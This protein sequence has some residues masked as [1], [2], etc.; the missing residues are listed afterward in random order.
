MISTFHLYHENIEKILVDIVVVF[1]IFLNIYIKHSQKN[2][3]FFL[4]FGGM[5]YFVFLIYSGGFLHTGFLWVLTFSAFAFLLNNTENGIRWS[6][7]FGIV[8][9]LIFIISNISDFSIAYSNKEMFI[10]ICV[11][12]MNSYLIY[13]FQKEVDLYMLRLTELNISLENRVESEIIKSKKKDQ[14]LNAQAKHAQMG[15]MISMIAHQ[16]RQPI[17]AISASAIKLK[18]END[19]GLMSVKKV[20]ETS[21]FIQESTQKMS[22]IINSF[23]EFSKPIREDGEFALSR[24]ISK[25]LKII[26]MQLHLN[27]IYIYLEYSDEAKDK[28]VQGSSNLFEQVILNLLINIKDAFEEHKELREK[29]VFIS[30][31][32]D[33][34]VKITDTA[35]GIKA[36]IIEKVFNPYFTTKEEGKGTGL[37]LYMSR[38]IMRTHFN[39]DLVYKPIENGSCFEIILNKDLQKESPDV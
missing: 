28:I 3:I 11:Y 35:G 21:E 20:N 32:N 37:G 33:G 7:T 6:L 9:L 18:L 22:E 38:K 24:A 27:S 1:L 25:S 4:L 15:E 30:I 10:L 19:M 8:L 14:I 34:N 13:V 36:E 23:L 2:K 39:G 31:D 16:W 12:S 29:N 26:E 5:F 17:N